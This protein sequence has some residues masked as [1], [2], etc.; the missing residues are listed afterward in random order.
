M[1]FKNIALSMI[2][3]LGIAVIAAPAASADQWTYISTA[4]CNANHTAIANKKPAPYADKLR[5][6]A[7]QGAL[8][9]GNTM[10]V[11]IESAYAA[12][13]KAAA[14][15]WM[16]ASNGVIRI[17]FVDQAGPG[18][19]V[20]RDAVMGD[21][22][23]TYQNPTS[24]TIGSTYFPQMDAVNRK[25]V[26]AHEMGHAMGLAYSCVGDIM[27]A[28]DTWGKFSMMPT[29]SDVAGVIQG[30][31]STADFTKAIS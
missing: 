25:F 1:K 8:Q 18:V 6:P 20:I 5:L 7:G 12:D 14:E 4:Q 24:I 15:S 22:A 31:V 2:A 9:N 27:K 30:R 17:N 29:K 10:N 23:R 11:K 19:V 16:A 26:I 28:R 13:I 3:A 21:F